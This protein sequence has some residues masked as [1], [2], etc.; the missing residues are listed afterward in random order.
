MQKRSNYHFTYP[1][2]IGELDLATMVS[3][4]RSRG[5]PR[6]S[7]PGEYFCCALS[8]EL[9]RERKFWFGLF[10]SQKVWDELI[11]KGSEGYPLTEA[12]FIILGLVYSSEDEPP[13]REYVERHSRVVDKLSYLILNDLRGFGFLVEDESG[14]VR[15]TPRGER[16]LHGIARRMYGK[17]FLP[18]MIDH[19]PK[20]EVPKIEEAQRRHQDQ[21]NLFI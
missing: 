7:M 9:L 3:M 2:N 8:H 4:Y 1:I 17:R 20:P 12:E 21:G 16:A 6:K 13:H 5:E 10:Y 19:T 18:E 15:I 14:Y 11:T